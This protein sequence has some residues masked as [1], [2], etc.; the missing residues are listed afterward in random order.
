MALFNRDYSFRGSH[1][2]KVIELTAAFDDKGNKL[3]IRN[4]DVYL[5]API[6][7]FLYGRKSA[8]DSTVKTTNI[9][10][11]AMSK[12]TN[13]LWFNYRLIMLL[14]KENEADFNL[15]VEKAFRQY[16]SEEAKPDEELYE[17]YVRGGVDILH[18][19]LIANARLA[20]D[21][22]KNLY[23]FMEEFEEK[24][25]QNSAEILDLVELARN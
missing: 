23:E 15:R 18:E 12:E 2:E 20:D 11:E 8:I 22:L 14:D 10:F 1:A 7:G 25:G 17:S 21:Y 9:L 6:V 16:G 13:T 5:I 3:F 24:Y 19:K 4:L